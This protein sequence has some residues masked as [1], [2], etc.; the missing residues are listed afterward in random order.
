MSKDLRLSIEDLYK[1]GGNCTN[2]TKFICNN[3]EASA[4]MVCSLYE[5]EFAINNVIRRPNMSKPVNIQPPLEPRC[6]LCSMTASEKANYFVALLDS[7]NWPEEANQDHCYEALRTAQALLYDEAKISSAAAML[8]AND[9]QVSTEQ[10]MDELI[11]TSFRY[12]KRFKEVWTPRNYACS[13]D[14]LAT[15]EMSE[16]YE[17]TSDDP[18][19]I[20]AIRLTLKVHTQAKHGPDKP[21][22]I[23]Q[24][25]VVCLSP[26]NRKALGL[27]TNDY[28]ND[29]VIKLSRAA[30]LLRSDSMEDDNDECME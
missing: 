9:P 4:E 14:R 1:I 12:V 30:G 25:C 10:E 26:Q 6:P 27:S 23:E 24:W 28:V 3:P 8:K 29:A 19:N 20:E 13:C 22:T 16:Q 7:F 15:L 11:A 17:D 2:C 5:G 21:W 18:D